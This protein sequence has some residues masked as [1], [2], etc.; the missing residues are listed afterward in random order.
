MLMDLHEPETAWLERLSAYADRFRDDFRR[1][2]QAR[3]IGVYLQA[4]LLRD[5]YPQWN[6]LSRHLLLPADLAVEDVTQA[7]QNFVNQ[8]PWDERRLW[9][10]Y[11][12]LTARPLA[13]PEG[14][15]VLDDLTFPKQ[16][17]HSAGVQR[18]YSTAWGK[19]INCQLA[20]ALHY[21]HAGAACPLSLRLYLPRGWLRSPQRLDAAGVPPEYRRPLSRGEIALELLDEVRAEGLPGRYVVAGPGYGSTPDFRAGLAARGLS[22]LVEV[23]ADVLVYPAEDPPAL[24]RMGPDGGATVPLHELARRTPP[25]PL[26]GPGADAGRFSWTR[27]RTEGTPLHSAAGAEPKGVLL[28]ETAAGT[29][30]YAL[31]DLPPDRGAAEAARVWRS[32]GVAEAACRTMKDRL[33]LD[34]FEGR[35]WRGFHH[36]A[37]LVMLAYGFLLN[38][39]A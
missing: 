5:R 1:R 35:S 2:D 23:P 31:A 4:L 6:D 7:L 13:G 38:Q 3:W 39:C 29:L 34:S 12:S 26:G 17:R 16:G 24:P 30:R 25:R 11:R 10:R 18:Q 27:L 14:V 32:R 20:V 9:R 22:Y 8:S 19:K 33:G 21:V 37:C 36:H 15:F 28:E